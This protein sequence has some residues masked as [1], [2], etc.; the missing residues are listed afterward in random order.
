VGVKDETRSYYEVIVARAL[1]RILGGIDEALDLAALARA[2]ALSPLHF[3]RIFRG[4]VG[5]TPLEL[6]RRLRLERAALALAT[7]DASVTSVAFDAGYET[8]ESF[9]RAFREAYAAS[10]S[11]FRAR[12]QEARAACARAPQWELAARSGI[13]FAIPTITPSRLPIH[14]GG[15]AMNVEIE[16]RP[17]LRVATVSHVGPYNTISEAFQRLG[18]IA[19]PAGLF[20]NPNAAMIGIYHD[21]PEATPAAELRS[22]AGIVV[23]PDVKLPAGLKEL[24]IPAGKYAHT[25]HVGSYKLLGDVWSRFMG[26]WLPKSGHRLGPGVAYELYRNTPMDVPESELATE[27]YFSV[28]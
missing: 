2:A 24:R 7:Q 19:G 5:E 1:G 18:Q 8:H 28:A 4:M 15:I 20:G 27:L 25:T 26:E 22:D 17:E 23:A 10:P 21:A 6:H 14:Q 16:S 11:E 9:T 13:H 12:A 3:H